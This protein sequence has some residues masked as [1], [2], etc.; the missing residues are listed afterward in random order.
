MKRGRRRVFKDPV[1]ICS[2]RAHRQTTSRF[3]V[4]LW[5]DPR[6]CRSSACQSAPDALENLMVAT[7]SKRIMGMLRSSSCGNSL[8][9]LARRWC[10][11]RWALHRAPI[12]RLRWMEAWRC[13]YLAVPSE[14]SRLGDKCFWIRPSSVKFCPGSSSIFTSEKTRTLPRSYRP[15]VLC[16]RPSLRMPYPI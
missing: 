12:C 14:A 7:F 4:S 15:H 9:F 3:Y 6:C 13:L 5:T 1:H 11:I 10:N 8:E 16:S 2:Q